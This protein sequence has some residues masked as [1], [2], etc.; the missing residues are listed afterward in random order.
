MKSQIANSKKELYRKKKGRYY[1]ET[2]IALQLYPFY[3][4]ETIIKNEPRLPRNDPRRPV[5][6]R[7]H[8]ISLLQ[9]LKLLVTS[10]KSSAETPGRNVHHTRG[11]SL[12]SN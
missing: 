6:S 3:K 9:Y 12:M 10:H 1:T 11:A 7:K 4:A 5:A 8:P 2:R